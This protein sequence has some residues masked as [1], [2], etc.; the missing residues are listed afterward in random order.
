MLVKT[1][2]LSGY[3]F[4]VLRGQDGYFTPRKGYA[5]AWSD[6]VQVLLTP[7]GSRAFN[8]SFGSS[9]HLCLF[10]PNDTDLQAMVNYSIRS[11]AAKWVPYVVLYDIRVSRNAKQTRIAIGFGLVTDSQQE[12]GN[13][14]VAASTLSNFAAVA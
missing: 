4:P 14:S 5:Q 7:I 3:G 10:E 6:L 11:S 1:N 2:T 9:L 13:I 12:T 8:R